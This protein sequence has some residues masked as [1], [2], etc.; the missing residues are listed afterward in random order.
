[1]EHGEERRKNKKKMKMQC[2]AALHSHSTAALRGS[3]VGLLCKPIGFSFVHTHCVIL[4]IGI[5][6][7]LNSSQ[8]NANTLTDPQAVKRQRDGRDEKQQIKILASYRMEATLF[9]ITADSS[10]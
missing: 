10:P 5:L 9:I 4:M 6:V 1:M 3:A 2:Y 7:S 8:Q